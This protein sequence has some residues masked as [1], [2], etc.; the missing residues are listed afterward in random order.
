MARLMRGLR[1]QLSGAS[2]GFTLPEALVGVTVTILATAFI[3]GA[4]FQALGTQ[5]GW[6]EEVVATRELRN[7]ASWFAGDAVNAQTALSGGVPPSSSPDVTLQWTDEDSITH[8]AVYQVVGGLLVRQYDGGEVTLAR[9]V[10]SASFSR[11][12]QSLTLELVV[13]GAYGALE[14]TEVTVYA[15]VLQ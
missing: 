4:I 8:T 13:T 2:P 12:G 9:D 5:R 7:A 6:S 14:T 10:S 3:G 1:A 15:R 11:S